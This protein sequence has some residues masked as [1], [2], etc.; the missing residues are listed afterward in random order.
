MIKTLA[1]AQNMDG[2]MWRSWTQGHVETEPKGWVGAFN[3]S[4]SLGS[5]FERLLNWEDSDP[6]AISITD[7]I[8]PVRL[9]SCVEL[10]VS[11]SLFIANH[12][13]SG[14]TFPDELSIVYSTTYSQQDCIG[15]N[16][17]RCS[18]IGLHQLPPPIYM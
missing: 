7:C 6:S 5:L 17:V 10:T 11:L 12:C 13:S 3:A 1:L 2:Q 15:G 4:I 9:L 16:A 14:S 8:T 18:P